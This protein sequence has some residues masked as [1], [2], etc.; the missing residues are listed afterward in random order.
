M[1]R[2]QDNQKKAQQV[3]QEIKDDK[4]KND[5][6]AKFLTFL[7]R[8]IKDD[9]LTKQLYQVFF[10]PDNTDS[11]SNSNKK[12]INTIIIVGMFAPFYEYEIKEFNLESTYNDL[13]QFENKVQLK[14]YISYIKHL[15]TKHHNNSNIDKKEFTKLLNT[16]AEY[17]HLTE[18][19]TK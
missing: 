19:K 7:L 17:F 5:K 13:W 18:P 11:E 3:Q 12:N 15:L 6:F 16:I 9:H 2:V 4:S 1:R 10:K 14:S 8:E